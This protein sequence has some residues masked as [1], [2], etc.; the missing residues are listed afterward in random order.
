MS[1]GDDSE[2][3]RI[4]QDMFEDGRVDQP[5]SAPAR[6]LDLEL[7]ADDESR[8]FDEVPRPPSYDDS[9]DES[10]DTVTSIAVGEVYDE[11]GEGSVRLPGT[12]HDATAPDEDDESWLST[13]AMVPV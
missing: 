5:P 2:L 11:L 4:Y 10:I 3:N 9:R 13:D 7:A 8:G 12:K 1:R 6:L